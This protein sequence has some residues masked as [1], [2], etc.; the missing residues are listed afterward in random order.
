[1]IPSELPVNTVIVIGL[2]YYKRPAVK[3]EADDSIGKWRWIDKGTVV[4]SDDFKGGWD[5]P[6]T[7]PIWEAPE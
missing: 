1:M 5:F 3:F 4:D 6:E 2:P 7:A